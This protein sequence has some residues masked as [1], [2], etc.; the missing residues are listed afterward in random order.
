MLRIDKVFRTEKAMRAA[1]ANT[2]ERLEQLEMPFTF[3][4][5][6]QVIETEHDRIAFYIAPTLERAYYRAGQEI[7]RV[8]ILEPLPAEVCA[9]LNSRIR[10]HAFI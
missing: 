9:Y 8:D 10:S 2:L 3:Y 7:D 6:K 4:K 1:I 5:Q